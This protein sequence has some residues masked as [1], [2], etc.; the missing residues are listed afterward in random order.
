MA[1]KSNKGFD[2]EEKINQILIKKKLVPKDSKI[3]GGADR[4]DVSLI[5]KN[6]KILIELKNKDKSA[7]YGQKEL[8]WTVERKW[9]WSSIYTC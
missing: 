4:E 5:Y 9:H 1:K 2:Y 8:L 7:D 6:N 3:T